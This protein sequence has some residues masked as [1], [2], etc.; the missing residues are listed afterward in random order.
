[1]SR[2]GVYTKLRISSKRLLKMVVS[3]LTVRKYS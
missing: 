2:E 3:I 1:M